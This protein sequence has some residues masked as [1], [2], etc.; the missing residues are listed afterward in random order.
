M[1]FVQPTRPP[2]HCLSQSLGQCACAHCC[3]HKVFPKIPVKLFGKKKTFRKKP[4]KS[5]KLR[6]FPDQNRDYLEQL[7][8]ISGIISEYLG[9]LHI[10]A[11]YPNP[12]LIARR[13]A[14]GGTKLG[15]LGLQTAA[16]NLQSQCCLVLA[17]SRAPTSVH[18]SERFI[19]VCSVPPDVQSV[20]RQK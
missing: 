18:S 1:W 7:V 20:T 3:C 9:S 8:F 11:N 6:G 16:V 5:T 17:T 2:R 19:I 12:S 14:C 4:L 13:A 10:F 15:L